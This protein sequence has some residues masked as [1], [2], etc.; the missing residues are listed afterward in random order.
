MSCW[1]KEAKKN[2]PLL[3][4]NSEARAKQVNYD[5]Y[6]DGGVLTLMVVC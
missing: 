3:K 5:L 4:L 1:N 2:V 6:A